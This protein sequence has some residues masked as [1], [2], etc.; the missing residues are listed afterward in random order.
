MRLPAWLLL[1]PLLACP[2]ARAEP[3]NIVSEAWPPYIYEEAGTLKGVDYDV[4]NRVLG[5]LGYEARWQLL[6]W[7]RALHDTANGSADAILD[8]S[9]NPEREQQYIFPHEPLS[10]SE[11]VLFYRI[12]RP[13]PFTGLQDL[14]GLKI[15]VSAGY[16]YGNSEFMH[17]DYFS[18]EPAASTEASLLMLMHERVDMVIMNKR[19]GQF[20]LRQLGLERQ[21]THHPLVVSSGALFLAFHRSPDMAALAKRFS[22]GLSTFKRSSEYLQILQHYGLT[23]L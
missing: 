12:D 2:M 1:L 14:R 16:V 22:S 20:T 19:A 15:G 3:L 11:S 4:T 18:R 23:E 21:V 13:H 8:I 7:R 17:A 9:P 5:Q 6:P 10:R